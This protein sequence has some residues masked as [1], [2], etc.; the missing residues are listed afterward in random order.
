ML[1]KA[2]LLFDEIQRKLQSKCCKNVVVQG[3]L[4]QFLALSLGWGASLPSGQKNFNTPHI[5]HLRP[6]P[7]TIHKHN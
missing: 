6:W 4:Y 7:Q 2:H 1:A 5:L 3:L